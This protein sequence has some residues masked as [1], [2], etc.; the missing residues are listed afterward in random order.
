MSF[1][2][3]KILSKKQ[4]S[5]TSPSNQMN[6][7]EFFQDPQIEDL[8]GQRSS[9][10]PFISFSPKTNPDLNRR[11]TQK[12][13]PPTVTEF[14]TEF[15]QERRHIPP[16]SPVVERNDLILSE[17]SDDEH[18][19][20]S[21][22]ARLTLNASN[23]SGFANK[24]GSSNDHLR[25]PTVFEDNDDNPRHSYDTSN[26]SRVSFQQ[27]R[28]NSRV[29]EPAYI[30]PE[31]DQRKRRL[32]K[33]KNIEPSIY[34]RA[35]SRAIRRVSKR[36]VNV[37]NSNTNI[38][39]F[40]PQHQP[41]QNTPQVDNNEQHSLIN[42]SNNH[43]SPDE[44]YDDSS[45]SIEDVVL[46]ARTSSNQ[47]LNTS[48]HVLPAHTSTPYTNPINDKKQVIELT[49]KTLKIFSPTNRLRLFFARFLCWKYV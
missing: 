11:Y 24:S 39:T 13:P 37:H 23:M 46:M 22:T 34:T 12:K 44:N 32:N 33:I 45:S 8:V 2:R 16:T 1:G 42:R 35:M 14:M 36:V 20:F 43:D 21:D 17:D 19:D 41:H 4:R 27:G 38:D 15:E 29:Y 31:V 7:N 6:E 18:E 47:P 9:S 10:S 40:P 26:H 25:P 48:N 28:P 49:G 30:A 5:S 3:N